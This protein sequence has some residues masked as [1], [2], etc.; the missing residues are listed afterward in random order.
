MIDREL[1]ETLFARRTAFTAV[2]QPTLA[3]HLGRQQRPSAL[4]HSIEQLVA[5]D[6]E[7]SKRGLPFL[8]ERIRAS[9]DRRIARYTKRR[10]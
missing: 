7:I 1:L 4:A 3:E 9:A 6:R 10:P 8:I 2:L 5:V